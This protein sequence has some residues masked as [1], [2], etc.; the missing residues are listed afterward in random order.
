MRVNF[1]VGMGR[2][3]RMDEIAGLAR[4]ADDCGFAHMTLV[5]EPYLARD[6]NVMATVAATNTR[7]IRIGQGVVDPATYHPSA[8]A[9]AAAS[10]CELTGGRAFLGIGAGGPFGKLMKPLPNADLREAVLFVRKFM[11]GEEAV[12]KG[13]RM[14][15]EWIR[16]PVPLYVAADGPR[17]LEL[18]G[19]VADGVYFMG[20]PPALVKW[21]VER[22]YRGAERAGR[23]PSRLDICVRS[24][25]YVTESKER[26][27][28]EAA[29][30]V[31][32][33]IRVLENLKKEPAIVELFQGLE[34]ES[35]GILDE[36]RRF[37]AAAAGY[38]RADGYNPWFE[39]IDAPYAHLMTQRIID[40]VHMIGTPGEIREKIARLVEA[41]A[42]TIATATYTIL[43]KKGMLRR[44]ADEIM[45]HFRN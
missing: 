24:Y 11:A 21:K 40:C 42:T 15:S 13:G 1:A 10:L 28:R 37:A 36:M 41:G 12:F 18:A 33:G 30:F 14:Q 16:G 7:R 17:A 9:N 25:I 5:D 26:A 4:L 2:N 32:F 23:D 6:V 8:L 20:G 39:K 27:W 43:D 45:P 34:R 22:I 44:I 35:P 3:E 29:G 31:P 19:E 38:T